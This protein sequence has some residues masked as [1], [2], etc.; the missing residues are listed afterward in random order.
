MSQIDDIDFINNPYLRFNSVRSFISSLNI[1]EQTF[2]Q[3]MS[4]PLINRLLQAIEIKKRIPDLSLQTALPGIFFNPRV[5]T[6]VLFD[7]PQKI[8]FNMGWKRSVALQYFHNSVFQENLFGFHLTIPVVFDSIVSS[9]WQI[10]WNPGPSVTKC[11]NRQSQNPFFFYWPWNFDYSLPE[12][13]VPSFPALFPSSPP[14][15]FRNQWPVSWSMFFNNFQQYIVFFNCPRSLTD[16]HGNP[17]AIVTD[18]VW[19][20]S[21]LVHIGRIILTILFDR[22]NSSFSLKRLLAWLK[23]FLPF[24]LI[25]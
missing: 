7:C 8:I 22:S 6:V 13:I 19:L 24:F 15:I 9:S 2:K 11:L 16:R 23:T 21:R 20:T 12:M 5:K 3:F 18:S 17:N 14:K 1:I 10:I 25:V 4:S